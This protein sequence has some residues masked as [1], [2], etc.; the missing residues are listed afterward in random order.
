[1][2]LIDWLVEFVLCF[3]L[4]YCFSLCFWVVLLVGF[5]WLSLVGLIGWLF[6]LLICFAVSLLV[7][8]VWV[9]SFLFRVFFCLFGFRCCLFWVSLVCGEMR[10]LDWFCW[11][12]MVGFVL[13]AFSCLD[14]VL[15]V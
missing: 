3:G 8:S 12:F 11:L 7:G 15:I 6:L 10:Q 14:C 5:C 4:D 9:F 2:T 13:F 1:M